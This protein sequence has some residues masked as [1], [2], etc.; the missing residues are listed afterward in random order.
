MRLMQTCVKVCVLAAGLAMAG[1]SPALATPVT[2]TVLGTASIWRAGNVSNPLN[3]TVGPTVID[4]SSWSATALRFSATGTT[5]RDPAYPLVTADGEAL[6]G[7]FADF[8]TAISSINAP[9]VS[10][11]GVFFGSTTGP[12]PSGLTFTT[13]ASMSFSTLSPALQQMFFIGDG[14]TGQGTGDVQTFIIPTGAQYLYLGMFDVG[15][16][17]NSGSLSVSI[18]ALPEPGSLVLLGTGIAALGLASRRRR[19]SLRERKTPVRL[20]TAV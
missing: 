10:L 1:S 8:S 2:V 16:T 15:N 14:L 4:L 3:D 11:V 18:E 7:Y 5:K 13:D 6:P 20:T 19:N 9:W 12:K 17:D